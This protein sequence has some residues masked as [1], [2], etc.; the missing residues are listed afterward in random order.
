MGKIGRT[1]ALARHLQESGAVCF[2][3]IPLVSTGGNSVGSSEAVITVEQFHAVTDWPGLKSRATSMAERSKPSLLAAIERHAIPWRGLWQTVQQG[4]RLLRRPATVLG[5]AAFGIV[6]SALVLIPAEFTITGHGELWPQRRRDVFATTSGIVD[7]ILVDHGDDVKSDQALIVLRDPELEQDVPR[8]SGEIATTMERLRSVQIARLT[9][10]VAPDA[11]NRARQ[12][13]AE[14]VELKERLKTMERQRLLI[15]ERRQRLTLRSPIAGRVLTWDTAQ[16]LSA[17]PVERGQ[18]LL[19]I[20]ETKGPWIVEIHVADKDAGYMLRA[21][22]S[23]GTGLNV[24]FQLPSEPGQTH[25]GRVYDV[26]MASESND[27]SSGHVRVLVEFDSAR[28]NSC[29]QEP[30]RS[31]ASVAVAGHSAMS[32]CTI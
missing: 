1:I 6:I 4:P 17:R 18:S 30:R 27:R 19:T 8:I 31:P 32:G 24:D 15:E 28:S 25:R 29:G 23:L 13:T 14:E 3:V 7:Q 5:I 12:L 10:G 20:G 16:H 26:A 22:T 11:V 2:G 9:G 21:Q